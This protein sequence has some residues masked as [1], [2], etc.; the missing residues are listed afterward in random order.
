MIDIET[1]CVTSDINGNIQDLKHVKHS[2]DILPENKSE[3]IAWIK[4]HGI[5]FSMLLPVKKPGP[6]YVRVSVQDKDT[7][8]IGSAYQF[9][10]IPDLKKK[11]LAL[12][13][14]FMIT[15]A[16]DLVWMNSDVTKELAEGEFSLVFQ[17]DE[18]RSPALRT[19]MFGDNLHT[20]T[21]I[22]NADS[23]AIARSEIEMQ[24]VLYKDG[25]EFHH[26]ESRPITPDRVDTPKSIPI[27]QRMTIGS[28]MPPGDY[29]LQLVVTDKKNSKKKEGGA[30][31]V[32]GFTVVEK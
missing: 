3:N 13:N 26:G 2:F 30:S 7:G 29:M 5:R 22:Y 28:N 1:L 18:I 15:S 8:K 14:I 16:D 10:E 19:Y 6:Y 12:S 20:L 27:L 11:G 21:M 4:Q 25:K 23:K 24:S 32:M 17:A 9:L 31:Q